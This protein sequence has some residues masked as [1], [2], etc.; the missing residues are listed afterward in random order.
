M[1]RTEKINIAEVDNKMRNAS[2]GIF[3]EWNDLLSQM[4][5]GDEIVEYSD[6]DV[7]GGFCSGDEGFGLLRDGKVI[8][9]IVMAIIN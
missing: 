2:P 1:M 9:K 8:A 6:L 4:E 5:A 7:Y 3:E